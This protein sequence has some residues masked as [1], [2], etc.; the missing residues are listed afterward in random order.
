MIA[1]HQRE[2]Q[3]YRVENWRRQGNSEKKPPAWRVKR[4]TSYSPTTQ[5]LTGPTL[6]KM[7]ADA[8]NQ[9]LEVAGQIEERPGTE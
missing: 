6:L 1:G 2:T 4:M 3:A 7:S 5:K 9:G 8:I